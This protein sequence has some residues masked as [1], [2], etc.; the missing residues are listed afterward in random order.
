MTMK[1]KR[2]TQTPKPSPTRCA[3]AGCTRR[4]VTFEVTEFYLD[5]G[6]AIRRPMCRVH[7][8]EARRAF[9]AAHPRPGGPDS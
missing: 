3:V 5:E 8:R 6:Y 7:G 9:M 1:A 4:V 2:P